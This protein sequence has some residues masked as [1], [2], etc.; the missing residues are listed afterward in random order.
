M[1]WDRENPYELQFLPGESCFRED[2]IGT[3][4]P[5]SS[6]SPAVAEEVAT[7]A[8]LLQTIHQAQMK[9]KTL[10]AVEETNEASTKQLKGHLH[11]LSASLVPNPGVSVD[12]GILIDSE[13]NL[14]W[15]KRRGQEMLEEFTAMQLEVPQHI[16]RVGVIYYNSQR[17]GSGGDCR[18]LQ[19]TKDFLSLT[20]ELP[21][22]Q[23]DANIVLRG[24]LKGAIGEALNLLQWQANV[25]LLLHPSPSSTIQKAHDPPAPQS[26]SFFP[27]FSTTQNSNS[28]EP[29]NVELQRAVLAMRAMYIDYFIMKTIN[30]KSPSMQKKSHKKGDGKFTAAVSQYFDDPESCLECRFIKIEEAQNIKRTII[31][32]IGM[33]MRV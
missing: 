33:S 11:S 21:P 15:F 8:H 2:R 32:C 23:K 12:F 31:S 28:S 20:E 13:D 10:R 3:P 30:K 9:L 4:S 25:R 1:M 16:I 5:S 29:N 14:Q 24:G 6:P 19:F 17:A 27:R 26:S 18:L 7:I 22:L